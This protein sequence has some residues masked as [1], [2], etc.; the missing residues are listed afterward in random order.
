MILIIPS[1]NP[2]CRALASLRSRAL[3]SQGRVAHLD[4][5]DFGSI[6]LGVGDELAIVP[7]ASRNVVALNSDSRCPSSA[8]TS[9]IREDVEDRCRETQL[10]AFGS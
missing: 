4:E 7:V 2:A 1:A 5:S 9:T 8:A 3:S 10:A 6:F